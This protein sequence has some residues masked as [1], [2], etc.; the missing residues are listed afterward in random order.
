MIKRYDMS[1]R[2]VGRMV[3]RWTEPADA[4]AADL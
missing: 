1:T 2:L 3:P 4:L